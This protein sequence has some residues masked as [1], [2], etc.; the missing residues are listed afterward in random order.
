MIESFFHEFCMLLNE[1]VCS[2]GWVSSANIRCKSYLKSTKVLT[3]CAIVDDLTLA[4]DFT[5]CLEWAMTDKLSI[6]D[7]SH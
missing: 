2:V 4:G 3:C 1:T 7:Q 6:K 5:W